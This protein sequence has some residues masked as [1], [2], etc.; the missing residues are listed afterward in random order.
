MQHRNS[1]RHHGLCFVIVLTI[2]LTT[3]QPVRAQDNFIWSGTNSG[4]VEWFTGGN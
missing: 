4:S 1:R 2:I 3:I